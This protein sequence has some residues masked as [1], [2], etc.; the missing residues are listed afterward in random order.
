MSTQASTPTKIRID[1]YGLDDL[2][3]MAHQRRASDLHLTAGLA[4]M[5]R[6]DGWLRP[7]DFEPLTPRATQRLVYSI[8][9]DHQ[10]QRFEAQHELDFSHG[11]SKLGRFRVNVYM[12]RGSVGA[13]FRLVPNKIPSFDQLGLPGSIR[14]LTA[15]SAGLILVTG[16]TGSGKS[17]TLAALVDNIN[18]ER[19]CHIVTIED[20][21]EYVHGH[22]R[23][24]V[25][26]RELGSDTYDMAAALR[27]VVEKT[28]TSCWS[29][30][31]ATWKP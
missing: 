31:S 7:M 4:P 5:L 14:T 20:P 24:M 1:D 8:L 15:K 18:M 27:A 17:T 11:I 28:R 25:N 16:P 19:P 21:I 30:K 29:A 10:I 3:T 26:Q 12:Q 23:A 2:L 13:A 22:R 9:N 6:I